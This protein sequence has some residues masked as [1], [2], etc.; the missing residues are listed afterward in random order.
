MIYSMT[1]YG[2]ASEQ[3][4]NKIITAEI[5]SVNNRYLD[6]SVRCPRACSFL[7]EPV[8]AMLKAAGATR[9]KVDIYLNIDYVGGDNELCVNKAVVGAYLEAIRDV[10]ETY[11]LPN[12]ATAMNIARLPDVFTVKKVE[13][14]REQLTAEVC[15]VFEPALEAFLRMRQTEGTALRGDVLSKTDHLE[16][17]M[18]A[19]RERMPEIVREY[20]EKLMTRMRELLADTQ[21]DESRILTEAAVVADRIATDEETVRL[22]SHF[23]QLRTLLD[24]AEPVGRKLD[25]LVQEIN[26]EINTIGSKASDL[27]VAKVILDMKSELEKIREQVQNIE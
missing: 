16:S 4:G 17:M 6:C 23:S 27:Q 2:R 20:R 3:V 24:A 9:G 22:E 10:A 1:G 15:A 18:L 12:D 14:D 11:N 21:I 7:E 26:R 8:K 13:E 25:F 19:V 5:R